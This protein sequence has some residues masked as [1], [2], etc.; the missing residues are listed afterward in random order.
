MSFRGFQDCYHGSHLGYPNEA[1]IAPMNLHV[2]P[3]Y[4]PKFQYNLAFSSEEDI[5]RRPQLWPFG[6]W[7]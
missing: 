5:I 6:Y 2:G 1:I 4:A 7:K 3:I